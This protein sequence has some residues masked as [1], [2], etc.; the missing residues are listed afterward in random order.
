MQGRIQDFAQGR[1]RFWDELIFYIKPK[2]GHFY[3]DLTIKPL[4]EGLKNAEGGSLPEKAQGG[5]SPNSPCIS[6]CT[7]MYVCMTSLGLVND[8]SL[9]KHGYT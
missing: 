2:I 3:E 1:D 5:Q 6:S 9:C 4:S 7:F 8:Y